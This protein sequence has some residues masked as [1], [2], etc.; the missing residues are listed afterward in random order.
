MGIAGGMS[1][2]GFNAPN[3]PAPF[4]HTRL[5][6]HGV[7]KNLYDNVDASKQ[8]IRQLAELLM[9]NITETTNLIGHTKEVTLLEWNPCVPIMLARC[10]AD[11][12]KFVFSMDIKKIQNSSKHY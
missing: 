9:S 1:K 5:N 4:R 8:K 10:H 3:S 11:L 2:F 12:L 7:N 6:I